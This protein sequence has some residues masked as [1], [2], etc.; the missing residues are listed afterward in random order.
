MLRERSVARHQ[1]RAAARRR[2][3]GHSR[4]ESVP[5]PEARPY[6]PRPAA[7]VAPMPAPAPMQRRR[8]LSAREREWVTA[9]V[10]SGALALA[11]MLAWVA[12]N[13]RPASPLPAAVLMRSN[14]MEQQVPF[15]PVKLTPPVM[16]VVVPSPVVAPTQAPA[17]TQPAPKPA[18][19]T[20]AV[21]RAP[22]QVEDDDAV[23]VRHFA[24]ARPP[25]YTAIQ[26][27]NGVKYFSDME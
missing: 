21:S 19:T 22:K 8:S 10:F 4:R 15:G 11:V 12:A 17:Q 7:P 2:F 23:V 13:R 6:H 3:A 27:R 5:L 14:S 1:S 9:A 16:P 24:P 26:S 20:R 25:V 18:R